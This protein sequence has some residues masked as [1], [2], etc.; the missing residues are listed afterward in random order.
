[1][2]SK[3]VFVALVLLVVTGCNTTTTMEPIHL[4]K[5]KY[6]VSS[7]GNLFPTGMEPVLENAIGKGAALCQRDGKS[8]EVISAEENSG[9]YVMGNYPKAT[10][11]FKCASPNDEVVKDATQGSGFFVSAQG[12][13]MT[14][15]H[16]IDGCTK[17]EIIYRDQRIKAEVVARDKANDIAVLRVQ[18]ATP[19]HAK[20]RQTNS[21]RL[22]EPIMVLGFPLQGL[23]AG[24]LNA[25]SGDITSLAGIGG[26]S[27]FVQIS[28]PVQPGNSG[29]PIV[30]QSGNVIGIATSKLNAL[31]VLKVTGDIPQNINFGV[32]GLFASTLLDANSIRYSNA[33]SGMDLTKP[34]L[35][36]K[37]SE[38]VVPVLCNHPE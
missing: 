6:I 30:D 32:K 26:D 1:M 29:G 4:G 19:N 21:L 7:R 12:H 17:L 38:F 28:A 37:G 11:T 23:L 34:Q 31:A 2:I 27:R 5:G 33:Q 25:T 22:A 14:N 9:P 8:I 36:E 24:Q 20:F 35:A 16:V 10:V 3:K 18:R 15:E 13:V